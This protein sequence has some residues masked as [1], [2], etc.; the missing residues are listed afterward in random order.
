MMCYVMAFCYWLMCNCVHGRGHEAAVLCVQ[1]DSKKIISGSCD[2]TIKVVYI[3]F[4]V[5]S[6]HN[7]FLR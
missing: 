1:F 2:K 3:E 7:L 4:C 6:F 5:I